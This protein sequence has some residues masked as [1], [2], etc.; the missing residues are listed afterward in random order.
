MFQ[1]GRVA[2]ATAL[3]ALMA[4]AALAQSP[5]DKRAAKLAEPW[6]KNADWITDYDKARQLSDE[7]G[8][9]IFAYFTRSYAP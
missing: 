9:P 6:V 7:S 2:A 8:K 4:A 1:P 5:Q 3:T